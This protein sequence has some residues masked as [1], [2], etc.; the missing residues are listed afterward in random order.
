M[1]DIDRTADI[2]VAAAQGTVMAEI[3]LVGHAS[4]HWLELFRM[5]ASQRTLERLVKA[6]DQEDR[7][8]VIV[9]LPAASKDEY[10]ESALDAVRA[11]ISEATL[12]ERQSQPGAAQTEA[13][14]RGWWAQQQ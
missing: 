11:L 5:L 6:E 4:E 8:W 2:K 12:I 9:T 3:P 10:P 14:I 1:P 13:V 7:A